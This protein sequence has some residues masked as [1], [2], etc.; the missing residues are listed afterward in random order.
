M[1][2][3]ILKVFPPRCLIQVKSWRDAGMWW[4]DVG[5]FI[6]RN[7]LRLPWIPSG[8]KIVRPNYKKKPGWLVSRYLSERKQRSLFRSVGSCAAEGQLKSVISWGLFVLQMS[9]KRLKRSGEETK[10]VKTSV[11][12]SPNAPLILQV[13]THFLYHPSL[14]QTI[15]IGPSIISP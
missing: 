14:I 2:V 13:L 4:R 9:S 5:L 15:E 10:K 1:N 8:R 6:I 3:K 7:V 12:F 11:N